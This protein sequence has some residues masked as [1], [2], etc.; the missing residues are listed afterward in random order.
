MLLYVECWEG[1]DVKDLRFFDSFIIYHHLYLD[2]ASDK[3]CWKYDQATSTVQVPS[4]NLTQQYQW[5][6]LDISNEIPSW[7]VYQLAF[8]RLFGPWDVCF[9]GWPLLNWDVWSVGWKRHS[10]SS[11]WEVQGMAGGVVAFFGWSHCRVERHGTTMKGPRVCFLRSIWAQT[12]CLTAQSLHTQ[13]SPDQT[14]SASMV[15]LLKCIRFD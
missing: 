14:P 1:W 12:A 13:W 9:R 2:G 6:T 3:K 10:S 4:N 7:F 8:I 5:T 11:L 15:A